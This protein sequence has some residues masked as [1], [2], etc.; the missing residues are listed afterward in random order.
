MIGTLSSGMDITKRKEVEEELKE[1]SRFREK[2]IQDANIW[3]NV[4]DDEANVVVWNK[5]AEDISG[6]PEEEVVGHDKIWELLYPDE[7]YRRE[8]TEKVEDI[9]SGEKI[10]TYETRI[11]CKNGEEK[12][13]SWNS[14]PLENDEGEVMGSIALG[15]DITEQKKA[16]EREEFLNILL[17]QD[18]RGK[19]QI[20]QGYLQL[21]EDVDLD[22]EHTRYLERAE[23]A[24][25]QISEI[26]ETAEELD[27]ITTQESMTDKEVPVVFEH[28]LEDISEQID[29]DVNIVENYEEGLKG[30][31]AYHTLDTLFSQILKVRL[32][33]SG[34]GNILIE[35]KEK[36]DKVMVA[37][38]DDGDRLP[39]DIKELFSGKSYTGVTAGAGGVRYYL[40]K[41]IAEH[42][43]AEIE[44]GDPEDG[45]ARFE[46][47][48]KTVEG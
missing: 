14:H 4:L 32:Q 45:G 28:V 36:N 33:E 46:V 24:G 37:I 27:K 10:E 29:S 11:R 12:M 3:L 2:I 15:R 17:K 42:N 35:G 19:F 30:V 20:I 40:L 38:Q 34:C 7:D 18:L 9:L 22:E 16:E 48:L 47:Y 13:I 39:E 6:Y 5:A 31:R 41:E 25:R 21:L 26:L 44:V 23:E 1:L 8:I 43:D